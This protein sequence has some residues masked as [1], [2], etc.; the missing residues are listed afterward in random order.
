MRLITMICAGVLLAVTALAQ[1]TAHYQKS[2]DGVLLP[3]PEATPGATL[4][5]TIQHL[6]TPGYAKTVRHVTGE[7]K[8]HIYALYGAKVQ[9]KVCCE[10]DHLIPLELGGSNDLTNLWPQPYTPKPGAHEK[11]KLEDALHKEVCAGK[12]KLQKAQQ[13][14]SK[15]WYA[16]YKEMLASQPASKS[17]AQQVEIKVISLT[18]PVS[19]GNP[20]SMTIKTVANAGCRITVQ[21][22]SG[23]SKAKGL[24][25]KT[26]NSQ[27]QLT[28]TWLVGSRTTPGTWPIVVTCSKGQIQGSLKTSF[29][30]Q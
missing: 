30:V 27:G 10:V 19:P 3:D 29:M 1:P 13:I 17:S 24:A 28:W 6:C 26:A 4:A 22:L 20:A 11:D 16:E 18:S 7:E 12:M 14:I 23:P 15:D 21:Y 9:P 5:V 8:R 2:S 25:P